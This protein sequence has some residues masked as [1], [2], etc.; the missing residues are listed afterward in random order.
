MK[1]TTHLGPTKYEFGPFEVPPVA[2]PGIYRF[3]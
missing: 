2:Q 3:S 1:S